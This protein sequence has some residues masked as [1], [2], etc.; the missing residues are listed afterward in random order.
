MKPIYI[1]LSILAMSN[2]VFLIFVAAMF[3]TAYRLV[4]H[5]SA[6]DSY[7]RDYRFGIPK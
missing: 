1:A 2:I 4:R 7:I 3:V 5:V 6:N